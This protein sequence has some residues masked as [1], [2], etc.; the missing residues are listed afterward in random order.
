MFA[1]SAW[2]PVTIVS[3]L[4]LLAKVLAAN[5][6]VD[7]FLPNA[8]SAAPLIRAFTRGPQLRSKKKRGWAW[9][10]LMCGLMKVQSAFLDAP[11]AANSACWAYF[12]QALAVGAEG[13]FH[14]SIPRAEKVLGSTVIFSVAMWLWLQVTAMQHVRTRL[15]DLTSVHGPP[16]TRSTS[17]QKG[18]G[19]E[20]KESTLART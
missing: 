15:R 11:T 20:E 17:A 2:N 6:F 12:M 3:E 14:Q 13:F 19:D 5:G 18:T 10:W 7:I 1:A 4:P 8:T 9:F 16:P